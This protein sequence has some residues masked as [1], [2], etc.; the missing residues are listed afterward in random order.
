LLQYPD[1]LEISNALGHP[2]IVGVV[3]E[4][5]VDNTNIAGLFYAN[6]WSAVANGP[7]KHYGYAFQWFAMFAALTVIFVV[8][9]SRR[10]KA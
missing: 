3:Q 6:N 4:A 7:E 5:K 9:N 2:V 1:Y 10:V 8:T